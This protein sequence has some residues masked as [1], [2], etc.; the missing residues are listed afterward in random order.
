MLATDIDIKKVWMKHKKNPTDEL[1]NI[2][3]ERY[4]HIVR[5]N[6][7]R[8]HAKLPTEVELDDLTSAGMFGLIDAIGAFDLERGV[9]FETYCSP[10]SWVGSTRYP[11]RPWLAGGIV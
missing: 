1:R 6:A 2:L 7:E 9:K 10:R 3:I 8:I 11:D 5:F 4:I